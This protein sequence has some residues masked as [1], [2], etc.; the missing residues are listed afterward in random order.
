[1]IY[2]QDIRYAFRLL[3]R[4]PGFT[5]LTVLVLAGGLGLSTF[6]F[7]FLY[8]AMMR[9][10][11][12][13]EGARVVRI[14]Q[15]IE[16]RRGEVDAADVAG[17]RASSRTLRDVG[18][19][20]GREV[21]VGREGD[22]RMVDATIADPVLFSIARTPALLGRPLVAADAA[23]DAEPVIVLSHRT[24][25][26]LFGADR[27]LLD[28]LVT[29]NDASA[30]VVGVM[31]EGFG[32]P[33]ASE[34]WIPLPGS[35]VASTEAGVQ[36]L[37]LAGRL[38]P[39]VTHAQAEAEVTPLLRR[40]LAARDTSRAARTVEA[41][42][43]S[44]PSVQFGEE[45]T[46]VFTVLNGLAALILLLALVNV[47]NLLLA[48]VNE[49]L[50]ETAVRLALGA[51]TGRLVMQGMWESVI[52]CV[53][54][55]IVG[56]AGAA[57]GLDAITQWTRANMEGNLAFWWVWQMDHV[58]LF[59]AG[60][61]VT[62]AI[63]VLGSVVSR[64]AIRINVREVMQDGSARSGSRRDGRLAGALVALQVTTVTALMFFGV[65]SGIM[66]RRVL[67][68]DPGYDVTNLLQGGVAP[69]AA[70]YRTPG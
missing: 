13:G 65:M 37:R 66:A 10:L 45:R 47:T 63:V 50:R 42:V 38:A 64:R 17:L 24:W 39:G 56:T 33:V 31:P 67:R 2:A 54:G 59:G 29:I 11:P 32:F 15:V 26:V 35:G 61:F 20:T 40:A 52:L 62:L 46:L 23:P 22:R 27:A 16:G 70:R 1:M 34:A 6:T 55:G 19:Y 25:E 30:R 28:Q 36:S 14:D 58:T 44:F 43:E 5:L 12:L 57:W 49:R 41:S 48:R 8:T 3:L 7:S 53:A 69:P 51:S 60:G 68:I 21:L 9:P 4:S 18:G